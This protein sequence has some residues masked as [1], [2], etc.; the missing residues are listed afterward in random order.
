MKKTDLVQESHGLLAKANKLWEKFSSGKIS[1]EQA[2]L[3][4][5]MLNAH[6]GMI[7][8]SISAERW[9]GVKNKPAKKGKK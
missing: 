1:V 2:K 6:K 3:S 7:N 8:T 5:S 4:T 9:Y